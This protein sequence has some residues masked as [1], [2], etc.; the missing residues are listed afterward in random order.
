MANNSNAERFTSCLL[1]N[2]T[3]SAELL[4]GSILAGG[5]IN[6]TPERCKIWHIFKD[7]SK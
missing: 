2:S 3:E 1:V 7:W 4:P 6:E 5:E